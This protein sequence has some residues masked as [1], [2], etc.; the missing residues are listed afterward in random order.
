MIIDVD[1]E[2]SGSVVEKIATRKGEM[3]DMRPSTGGKTRISF[4]VPS[5]GLIGY[6]SE[7]LTDTKGTGIINRIFHSFAPHKGPLG[8]KR[9]GTLISVG[10]GEAVSYAIWN[11]QERGV[12]FVKPGDKVYDGMIV[13]QNSKS[14]DL[15][16]N[17]LKTKQL[18]NVR[19]SGT[20]EAIR[21]TPPKELTLEEMITYVDD[22]ELV[23]VTP[24]SLRLRKK[25]L[26]SNER[27][28]MSRANKT[29]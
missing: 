27:K 7:F 26:D 12:I 3:T 6:Q 18:T 17:I 20:D 4:L 2:F 9:N 24:K 1:D 15:E 25:Y 5:R 16:V 22:D 11:L 23:E 8:F 10:T 21:L 13:G 28:K 29:A 19:A 14:G